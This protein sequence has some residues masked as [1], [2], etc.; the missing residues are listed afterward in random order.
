MTLPRL[1]LR[2]SSFILALITLTTLRTHGADPRLEIERLEDG[3]ARLQWNV[4]SGQSSSLQSSTNL[5]D[6]TVLES[7]PQN[8]AEVTYLDDAIPLLPHRFYRLLLD[9]LD[10]G[11][12]P[13]RHLVG[14]AGY[15]FADAGVQFAN[16]PMTSGYRH[17]MTVD[18]RQPDPATLAVPAGTFGG[19]TE[20][21][22]HQNSILEATVDP[23]TG[24]LSQLGIRYSIFAR[25]GRLWKLD[26]RSPTPPVP[27]L[28]TSLAVSNI[29]STSYILRRVAHDYADASQSWVMVASPNSQ[30]GCN[31]FPED[32]VYRALRLDM[33][34][35]DAPLEVPRPVCAV[36]N[37]AGAIE[38]FVVQ[39][40]RLV[41][42][43]DRSFQ[44]PVT[45][46][47]DPLEPVLINGRPLQSPF[48]RGV[49]FGPQ[50]PG[51][52]LFIGTH[53]FQ[54]D[55][56]FGVDLAQN[57][58][59]TPLFRLPTDASSDG[60]AVFSHRT[61]ADDRSLYLAPRWGIS[62]SSIVRIDP[63]LS[64]TTLAGL[65]VRLDELT[66]TDQHVIVRDGRNIRAVPK[67]GGELRLLGVL[68][69]TM[70]WV[71][72]PRL[73]WAIRGI[74][75][76]T[77]RWRTLLPAGNNVWFEGVTLTSPKQNQ[78][79]RLST[80]PGTDAVFAPA[81]SILTWVA[82]ASIHWSADPS[83]HTLYIADQRVP[84]LTP[85]TDL[86]TDF[87][88]MPVRAFRG[89]SGEES[90]VL[91]TFPIPTLRIGSTVGAGPINKTVVMGDPFQYGQPGLIPVLGRPTTTNNTPAGVDLFHFR[92][93]TPGLTPVTRFGLD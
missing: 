65:N 18:P 43:V 21:F 5:A 67:V 74:E 25:D 27:Q 72:H 81:K 14:L 36:H 24:L 59:A 39:D 60:N 89:D 16:G 49:V 77:V 83:A 20:N 47:T 41:Q 68:P 85:P 90:F 11:S 8:P 50:R 51:L 6:W 64:V 13:V 35:D 92:S 17:L 45:L 33:G 82:P 19:D 52:W 28:W 80:T 46:Y 53:Q 10:P 4:P 23:A 73:R 79:H 91:G 70:E 61:E 9:P 57:S 76:V 66:L 7:F 58:P 38:G 63:D 31:A 75:G 86:R 84:I 12:D 69:E 42:R 37:A 26:H 22:I 87:A 3:R 2:A 40:G 88:G 71:Q 93:D 48:N 32:V 30:G 34:P 62:T 15:Q 55:Y 54:V 78:V 56:L 44:N 1:G 29:C